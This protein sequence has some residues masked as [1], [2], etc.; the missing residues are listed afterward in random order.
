MATYLLS[1]VLQA[2]SKQHSGETRSDPFPIEVTFL[3]AQDRTVF[4]TGSVPF[5]LSTSRSVAINVEC[6]VDRIPAGPCMTAAGIGEI[7]YRDLQYGLH[8][9]ASW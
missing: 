8:R 1:L 7:H 6:A 5:S 4:S 3:E 2:C 9:M